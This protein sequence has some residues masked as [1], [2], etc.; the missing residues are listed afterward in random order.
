MAAQALTLVSNSENT[1]TAP[2]VTTS[3]AGDEV[4]IPITSEADILR[5]RKLGRAMAA[6]LGFWSVEKTFIV[7]AISE[8][9]L[10]IL[11]YAGKGEIILSTTERGDGTPG[12]M[13]VARDRGPGIAD[14]ELAMQEGYSTSGKPGLG[15]PGAKRLMDEFEIVSEPGRGTTVIMKKWVR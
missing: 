13:I 2:V 1:E 7:M 10:N 8:I 4:C 5:A 14:V 9:A 3:R 11:Q 12:I 15:L 6:R